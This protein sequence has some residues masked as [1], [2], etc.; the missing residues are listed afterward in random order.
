MTRGLTRA[1]ALGLVKGL[2]GKSAGGGGGSAPRW[3]ANLADS[4]L[5][6]AYDMRGVDGGSTVTLDGNG[7]AST[8]QDLSPQG[9]DATHWRGTGTHGEKALLLGDEGDK[10]LEATGLSD[11]KHWGFKD[12]ELGE[13]LNEWHI[14]SVISLKGSPHMIAHSS[15]SSSSNK[16][17][18]PGGAY[19]ALQG[20]PFCAFDN[21][22]GLKT[23]QLGEMAM[24]SSSADDYDIVNCNIESLTG[25]VETAALDLKALVEF[26]YDG[27]TASAW[28]NGRE[29]GSFTP[30]GSDPM[31]YMQWG[32]RDLNNAGGFTRLSAIAVGRPGK[33]GLDFTPAKAATVRAAILADYGIEVW[34][35]STYPQP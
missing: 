1:A 3:F 34:D 15:T 2:T 18:F 25:R 11:E 32:K 5:L 10:Y 23:G 29:V 7:A 9:N 13:T 30:T 19:D 26:R 6:G 16:Y 20:H 12:D 8:L 35:G 4:A 31:A 28:V 17:R 24:T 33:S 21:A 27:T 14:F 22:G